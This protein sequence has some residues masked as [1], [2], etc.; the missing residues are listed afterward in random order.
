MYQF[1]C[2]SCLSRPGP[3]HGSVVLPQRLVQL[4]AAP[5]A[6][7]KVRLAHVA[8]HAGLRAAHLSRE[9]ESARQVKH[10]EP[11]ELICCIIYALALNRYV[12]QYTV[13]KVL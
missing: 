4:H 3:S 13:I 6:L 7:G 10:Q 2:F 5:L 8:H 11:K 12:M 1:I 9:K